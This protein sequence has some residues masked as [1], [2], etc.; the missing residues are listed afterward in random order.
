MKFACLAAVLALLVAI[1]HRFR[2]EVRHNANIQR[3]KDDYFLPK[4][5]DEDRH[6]YQ[7]MGNFTYKELFHLLVDMAVAAIHPIP[8]YYNDYEVCS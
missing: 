3:L 5:A 8:E 6:A 7:S 2:V 4:I 1:W